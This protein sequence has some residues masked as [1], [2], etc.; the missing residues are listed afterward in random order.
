MSKNPPINKIHFNVPQMRVRLIKAQDT[1]CI[2]GR[3][4]G[5]STGALAPF[6]LDN[7]LSMPRGNGILLGATYEQ[8]QMRT[9]P[10]IIAGWEREGYKQGVHFFVGKFAPRKWKW[11]KAYIT[12][13]TAKYYIHW[14]NGAGILLVSQDRAGTANGLSVDWIMGDEAKFLKKDRLDEETIP[15]MRGNELYFGNNSAH[16]SMMFCTDMPKNAAN[17]WVLEKEKFVDR[18]KMDM[19]LKLSM[20]AH[21]LQYKLFEEKRPTI[22]KRLTR[23]LNKI[24]QTLNYARRDTVLVDYASTFD[25]I[26]ALGIKPLKN[27]KRVLS[28]LDFRT[29]ILNQRVTQA[30]TRYYAQ[31]DDEYHT[32]SDPNYSYID[33]L[34][35]DYRNPGKNRDCRWDN[36][37][38]P[39][40]AIDIGF[41]YNAKF[42]SCVIGQPHKVKRQQ[43]NLINALYVK[44]PN[45]VEDLVK[46]I[47]K[48]YRFAKRKQVNYYHDHTAND[49]NPVTPISPKDAIIGEFKKQGW[50]VKV[51]DC[52]Q[53]PS[54]ESR[55]IFYG[56]LYKEDDKRLP[57]IRINETACYDLITSINNAGIRTDRHRLEKDKRP[58][59]NKNVNPEDATH[60]SEAKDSLLFPM[61]KGRIHAN[62]LNDMS[63]PIR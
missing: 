25:N 24:N 4:T 13:E 22:R 55:Y 39:N 20:Y 1:T 19:I 38:N 8:I 18:E 58:E 5:K 56:K 50:K 12:P 34:D 45:R 14:F 31:F 29:S 49:S 54:H 37:Y 11:A 42:N 46:K 16:F 15:T 27:Y 57:I 61:F 41:D 10:A 59:V 28:D 9:L 26:A 63:V 33:T 60:L 21:T 17:K 30:D 35:L 62:A 23:E 3:G 40:A 7:V 43:Y 2:W 36:D 51:I 6:S 48:Y 47:C 44:H 32:Y 53:A 52:G